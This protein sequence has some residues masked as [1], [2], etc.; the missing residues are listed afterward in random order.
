MIV[1]DLRCGAR[2]VFE[3]WFGSTADFDAQGARGLISC[4]ICGDATVTKAAM[5]PAVPAKGNQRRS[6]AED[7]AILGAL[8]AMQAEVE[9]S[10]DYVGPRFAVE[11][12]AIHDG[13]SLPRA[14]F[15][16][17][18]LHDAAQLV[19]DGIAVAPLPFRSR[20][21]SDA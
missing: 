18:T 5:A 14:I 11:A 19:A 13:D 3:A 15:G 9:A 16:E 6:P 12:R 10:S 20:R 21:N 1:F 17:A 4:P 2:H 8:A 7:K